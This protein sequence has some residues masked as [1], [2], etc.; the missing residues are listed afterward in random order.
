MRSNE[1]ADPTLVLAFR[2]P[3]ID[4]QR[5]FLTGQVKV[6]GFTLETRNFTTPDACDAWDASFGGLMRTAGQEGFPYVSIPAFPNRK[7]R[8]QYCY[9]SVA[10]GINS[11]QDLEGK[12]VY[13]SSTAGVWARG[14]LLNY[15]KVD[16]T[17]IHWLV[18]GREVLGTKPWAP[19]IEVEL[20]PK[21][22]NVDEMLLGGQ[23][24]AVIDPNVLPSISNR[25]PKVRRLF[26]DFKAAEHRYFRDTGIFPISHMVSFNKA[27]VQ[28]HPDAPIAL[29]KAYRQARDIALDSVGGPEGP[30]Y[31]TLPWAVAAQNEALD[32]LGERYYAYNVPDNTKSLEAMML[33]AHQFGLTPTQLDYRQFLHEEAA[34]YPGW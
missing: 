5:P 4:T 9:V 13:V 3:D 34:A 33:F 21:G 19:G 14:A 16:F 12:R 31:V 1:M 27:F 8:L 17:R 30:L 11:P 24:D 26:P 22:A 6:E 15:Y 7:F 25:N 29:L 32:L 18:S 10:S 20:L 23:L 2:E 28:N